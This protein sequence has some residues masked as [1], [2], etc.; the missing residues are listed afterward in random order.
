MKL[1]DYAEL[2]QVRDLAL[3]LTISEAEK[4]VEEL[5]RLLRDPEDSA[6]LRLEDQDGGKLTCSIVTDRKLREENY[7]YMELQVL[8]AK[9]TTNDG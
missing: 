3:Y 2:R 4:M 7:N 9:R 6:Q 8:G 1:I 5:G